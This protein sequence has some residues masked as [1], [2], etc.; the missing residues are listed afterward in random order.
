MT[1][2]LIPEKY[3]VLF[4]DTG[5]SNRATPL[6]AFSAWR[7]RLKLYPAQLSWRTNSLRCS[8]KT[9]TTSD[10][11]DYRDHDLDSGRGSGRDHAGDGPGHDPGNDHDHGRDTD[12]GR[13]RGRD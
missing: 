5:S 1:G 4:A 7:G 6:S 8:A 13:D 11:D 3:S 10:D 12:P 9:T 2:S